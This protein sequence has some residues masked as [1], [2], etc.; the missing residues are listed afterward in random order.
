MKSY[1]VLLLAFSVG[2]SQAQR[3][4]SLGL[5]CPGGTRDALNDAR[6]MAAA[7]RTFKEG[8]GQNRIQAV[9]DALFPG[10]TTVETDRIFSMIKNIP[11]SSLHSNL[12]RRRL[13]RFCR[14][15]RSTNRW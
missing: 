14:C 15:N 10:A 9:L 1:T 5:N 8:N 11:I 6:E 12:N 4:F 2:C 3:T 7:A 13:A